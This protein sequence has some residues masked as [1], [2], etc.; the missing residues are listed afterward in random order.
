[1]L[2]IFFALMAIHQSAYCMAII[3]QDIIL[4]SYGGAICKKKTG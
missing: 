3:H 4:K 2:S 1:M